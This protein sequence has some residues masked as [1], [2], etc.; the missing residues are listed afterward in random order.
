[1]GVKRRVRRLGLLLLLCFFLPPVNLVRYQVLQAQEL[2]HRAGNPRLRENLDLRGG[3]LDRAARPLALTLSRRSAG[4]RGDGQARSVRVYPLGAA[5]A[6]LVGYLT[7]SKG[8]G[9]LEYFLDGELSGL[10]RPRTPREALRLLERGTRRGQDV[11]LTLDA[12]LQE[13][14]YRLLGGRRGAA[15][16]LDVPTGEVLALA[17]RPS[18]DPRRVEQEWETLRDHPGH[19][20]IERGGQGLYPPG[21]TFKVLVMAAALEEGLTLADE[22]FECRG[23]TIVDGFELSDPS[24]PHG[25]LDLTRALSVSCNVTFGQVGVRLGVEGIRR[26]MERFGLLE[27]PAGVP[28]AR[29]GRPPSSS[30]DPVAAAQAGIGQA[31]LLVSPLGMAR[32]AAVVARRGQDRPP[33]L[34]RAF[35]RGEGDVARPVPAEPARTVL[36]PGTARRVAAAMVSAVEEGT[37]TAA[38]LPTVAVAGKTGTAENPQ[39]PPHAWFV[40]FAPAEDPRVAVA[41]VLENAGYGGVRA[42]PLARELLRAALK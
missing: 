1:M 24:P 12:S 42:A 29:A 31:D 7:S 9:G 39:G 14:A 16:V 20:F 21:S 2:S 23:R 30:G 41:V 34:L 15:V 37:A 8:R 33:R 32:L 13:T 4:G 38:R 11:F 19:P 28:G 18:F 10:H 40:G 22:L 6:P 3:I 17:S 36:S 26:W 5:A 25:L 27:A 35:R